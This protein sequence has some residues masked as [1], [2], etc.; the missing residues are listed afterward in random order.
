MIG[1]TKASSVFTALI[2]AA[3]LMT[4]QAS[5]NLLT[6]ASFESGIEYGDPNQPNWFAFFGAGSTGT[7]S[8]SDPGYAGTI[9]PSDGVHHLSI[10]NDGTPGGFSG[11]FQRVIGT[12]GKD[13]TFSFD[14]KSNSG[15]PFAIGAEFR[16]EFLDGSD[17]VIGAT[18]NTTIGG[19]LTG[20]YQ[21]FSLTATAPVG[22]VKVA[23]VIAVETFSASGAAG[24]LFVDNASLTAVPEPASV[25]LMALGGLAMIGRRRRN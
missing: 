22:T 9:M 6:N 5:A 8:T 7:E 10:R 24:D 21:T 11:V 12:G 15:V 13:Y 4:G 14:A 23:P 20:A 19:S 1:L 2:A 3:V 16:L 17:G 25:A 18:P